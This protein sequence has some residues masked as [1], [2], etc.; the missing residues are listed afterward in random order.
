MTVVAG[1]YDV[2]AGDA[3]YECTARG[4]FRKM[5][6]S[7][8]TGD[9]VVFAVTGENEGRIES[10][11]PRRNQLSR[12]PVA[13]VDKI[14]IVSCFENPS[15]NLLQI[16]RLTAVAYEHEIEP[17]LVFNKNDLGDFGDLPGRYQKA[18]F[19]TFVVSAKNGEGIDELRGA[20]YGVCIFAGNSGV[21]KSSLLN[22]LYGDLELKTGQVSEKLG[23]GRHT[24][25]QVSLFAI[26]QDTFV[27]DTPGFSK[28]DLTWGEPIEPQNLAL[29]FP[30][31]RAFLGKCRFSSCTHTGEAG[32][33]I[34]AAVTRGEIAQSR[35]QNYI[36][37]Y[38]EADALPQWVRKK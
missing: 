10:V 13:N 14:V 25:R 29:D 33:A 38:R 22:A 23:R 30:E 32:C 18:G 15:P 1:S 16:D 4:V 37:L 3:H 17:I 20:L 5:G 28:L 8:I 19:S 12:P 9:H 24:T 31:F 11:L 21:G 36:T 2:K 6:E 7:P 34:G 26:S 35:H 27:G